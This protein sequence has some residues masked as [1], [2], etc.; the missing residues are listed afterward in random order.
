M[1]DD[2]RGPQ[3]SAVAVVFLV[4]S[5]VAIILRVYVRCFVKSAFGIDDALAIVSL[6]CDP[7]PTRS[8]AYLSGQ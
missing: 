3:A 4:T 5:W 8:M 7:R 1:A 2:N 6:V